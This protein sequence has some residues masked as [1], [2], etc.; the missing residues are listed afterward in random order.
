VEETYAKV[1]ETVLMADLLN[2]TFNAVFTR[3]GVANEPEP[4][5]KSINSMLE[6][7]NFK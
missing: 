6:T 7:V 5:N 1:S 2:N 4:V 3:E